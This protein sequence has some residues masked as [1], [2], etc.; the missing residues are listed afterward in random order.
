VPGQDLSQDLA[1]KHGFLIA[2]T[3]EE[4]IVAPSGKDQVAGVLSIGE[5][6]NYP[7]TPDTGQRMY[8]RRRFFDEIVAA[9]KKTGRIV[10]VFNDKHLAYRWEDAKHMV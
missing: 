3:I 10:P 9:M 6:G 4:A 5:H 1:K 2:K 7:S 8:P